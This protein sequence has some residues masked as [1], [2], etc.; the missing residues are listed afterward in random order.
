MDAKTNCSIWN[1]IADKIARIACN[2][3]RLFLFF[4]QRQTDRHSHLHEKQWKSFFMKIEAISFFPFLYLC[5]LNYKSN[6]W[7]DT[8]VCLFVCLFA[9]HLLLSAFVY[10]SSI[11]LWILPCVSGRDLIELLQHHQIESFRKEN[12]F[13]S[14]NKTCSI[15][16]EHALKYQTIN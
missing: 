2:V 6:I 8:C 11:F 16:I 10:S 4:C 3:S 7:L 5:E 15:F 9:S 12:I 1:Q 13:F 14:Q